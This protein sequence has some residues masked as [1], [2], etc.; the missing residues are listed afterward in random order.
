MIKTIIITFVHY[1]LFIGIMD[2]THYNVD[3]D[4]Y[5]KKRDNYLN[6]G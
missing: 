5:R 1:L 2:G 3:Y 6:E 4:R